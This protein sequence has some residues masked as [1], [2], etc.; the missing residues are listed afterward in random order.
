MRVT[1]ENGSLIAECADS[2]CMVQHGQVVSL[3]NFV[4]PCQELIILQAKNH[5]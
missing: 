4:S 5:D 3:G 2:I 1:G